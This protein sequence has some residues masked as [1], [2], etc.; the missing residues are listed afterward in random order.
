MRLLTREEFVFFSQGLKFLFVF[1]DRDFQARD[2]RNVFSFYY[3]QQNR[4]VA[5]FWSGFK[6]DPLLL[7]WE[8]VTSWQKLGPFFSPFIYNK[9]GLWPIWSGFKADPL[10]LICEGVTSWQKLDPFLLHLSTTK[11]DCGHFRSGFKANPLLLIGDIE[12]GR[13]GF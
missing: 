13:N 11:R 5:H 12:F 8:G 10:L 3:L 1:F 2:L 6:A 9:T 4:I 7:F